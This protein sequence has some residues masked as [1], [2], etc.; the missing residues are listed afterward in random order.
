MT[1]FF[2]PFIVGS[3]TTFY[4]YLKFDKTNHMEENITIYIGVN[5]GLIC[6]P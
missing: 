2:F 4:F 5:A 1:G 3:P 6:D